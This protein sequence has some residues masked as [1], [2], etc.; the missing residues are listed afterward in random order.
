MLTQM[1]NQVT[2]IS[3]VDRKYR[4]EKNGDVKSKKKARDVDV[5]FFAN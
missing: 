3:K 4:K 5:T 1:L 2:R